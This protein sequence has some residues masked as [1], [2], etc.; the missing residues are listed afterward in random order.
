MRQLLGQ[1][2]VNKLRVLTGLDIVKVMVRGGTNH[3][4]DLCLSDGYIATLYR[5]ENPIK[6][7]DKWELK[8]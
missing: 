7:K 1:K 5:N 8:K 6:T 4:L 2:K 3:R